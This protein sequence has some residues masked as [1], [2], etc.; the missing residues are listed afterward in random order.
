[1]RVTVKLNLAVYRSGKIGWMQRTGY[2]EPSISNDL[3]RREFSILQSESVSEGLVTGPLF[4][5][6]QATSTAVAIEVRQVFDRPCSKFYGHKKEVTRPDASALAGA[7]SV[8]RD[9]P[10]A[11]FSPKSRPLRAGNE[12]I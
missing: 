4:S 8:P 7:A 3:R 10:S 6:S 11:T 12:G 5:K 9:V 1:L 2:C